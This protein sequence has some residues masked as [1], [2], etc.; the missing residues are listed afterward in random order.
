MLWMISVVVI[1]HAG[2][3]LN[4]FLGF[5]CYARG[6]HPKCPYCINVI[7]HKLFVLC[8]IGWLVWGNEASLIWVTLLFIAGC[9]N[10]L[11]GWAL[12]KG[13]RKTKFACD[14]YEWL[15]WL[16]HESFSIISA[17]TIVDWYGKLV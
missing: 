3:L 17:C 4:W 9:A 5:R 1:G 8:S 11:L 14:H 6:T 15:I 7:I 10:F 16:G 12:E 2:I 13:T